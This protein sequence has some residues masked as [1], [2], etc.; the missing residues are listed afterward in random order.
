MAEEDEILMEVEAVEAVYGD[1]CIV[2]N[3]FPP[4]LHLHLK[5]RTAD[6]DSQQFVEAT[7]ELRAGPQ[8]PSDPP[9]V[10][11]IGSK[12]LDEERQMHLSNSLHDKAQE[13]TSCLMLVA[14]CED[15]V[16]ILTSMNH[17][18]GDCPLCLYPLVP[19]DSHSEVQPFM[20]LM[21]CFHC[22]HCECIVRWLTWIQKQNEASSGTSN[23]LSSDVDEENVLASGKLYLRKIMGSTAGNCPV[24]RKV[25]LAKDIEHVLNLVGSHNADSDVYEK[26][27]VEKVL[28][29]DLETTR[30]QEFE[31]ILKLQQQCGGLIEPPKNN[32]LYSRISVQDL[33]REANEMMNV[34]ASEQ[35]H[36]NQIV[37][38]EPESSSS[39]NQA[40]RRACD[41]RTRHRRGHTGIA[42]PASG[43]PPTGSTSGHR[44]HS[45]TRKHGK[46]QS[47]WQAKPCPKE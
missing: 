23:T 9:Y 41:A 17:P 35:Q 43:V 27:L 10:G 3:R 19:E 42:E 28:Q 18:E 11:I 39:S 25:F 6:V 31:A 26:E 47:R 14:L 13:L 24:C 7:I 22:F 32:V 29:C 15:A 20:K 38:E 21:S 45:G 46:N 33:V 30:R 16:E 5:P 36:T 34:E 8:Y 37:R 2:L 40:S 4:H 44:R 1:D 12:G